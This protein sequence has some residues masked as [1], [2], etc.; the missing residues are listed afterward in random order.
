MSF[1]FHED[2]TQESYSREVLTFV[3]ILER[4]GGFLEVI[5][6]FS[7][8]F[9]APVN[10]FFYMSHLIKKLYL[11]DNKIPKEKEVSPKIC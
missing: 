8:F 5:A 9:V 1:Y 11:F 7:I 4:L 2:E 3:E 10:K 6:I